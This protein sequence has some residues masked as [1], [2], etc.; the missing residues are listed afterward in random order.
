M[1]VKGSSLPRIHGDTGLSSSCRPAAGLAVVPCPGGEPAQTLLSQM[2]SFPVGLMLGRT[3]RAVIAGGGG[4]GRGPERVQRVSVPSLVFLVCVQGGRHRWVFPKQQW[5]AASFHG[6][7]LGPGAG[8]RGAAVCCGTEPVL[9]ADQGGPSDYSE[10]A[11][12]FFSQ[13]LRAPQ[14]VARLQAG[15]QGGSRSLPRALSGVVCP[16]PPDWPTGRHPPLAEAGL[17]AGFQ[18]QELAGWPRPHRR[19]CPRP[20]PL[21]LVVGAPHFSHFRF[22]CL[23]VLPGQHFLHP[24]LRR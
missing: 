12:A 24:L 3:S 16:P 5:V 9:V 21:R 18:T 11:S 15:V 22:G 13:G 7:R 2:L 23:S 20:Q 19:P 10:T 14:C 6:A 17:V 4:A 8:A 1:P